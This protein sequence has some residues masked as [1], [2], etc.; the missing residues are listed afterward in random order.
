MKLFEKGK[1]VMSQVKADGTY[2]NAIIRG[3]DV[4]LIS[5]QGKYQHLLVLNFSRIRSDGR[6]CTKW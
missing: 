2:R 4:E 1:A 5:R 6:L 3:G